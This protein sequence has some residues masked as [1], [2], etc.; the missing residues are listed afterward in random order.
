MNLIMT[1]AKKIDQTYFN[2][3][4]SQI[5][6]KG[7]RTYNGLFERMHN[8]EFI[9]FV[10]NDDNRIHDGLDLRTEFI[11]DTH[12]WSTEKILDLDLMHQ[13]GA[14]FLEVLIALSRRAAFTCGGEAQ[15]WAWHLIENID[16][17]KM[18]DPLTNEKIAKI[19]DVFDTVIWRTYQYNGEGGFFPL[20]WPTEDQT[21][22]EIWYQLNKYA[23]EIQES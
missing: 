17:Q 19:D 5:E 11:H 13:K 15:F 10:P 20:N 22:V 6:V 14:S 3:L 8:T 18:S 21:K 1:T 7:T 9:W 16:L 23:L 12:G 4:I 2:W